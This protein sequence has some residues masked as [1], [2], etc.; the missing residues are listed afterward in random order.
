MW[1]AE[2]VLKVKGVPWDRQVL[3]ATRAVFLPTRGVLSDLP[4]EAGPPGLTK[5]RQVYI[6]KK[7]LDDIYGYTS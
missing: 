4:S 7:D 6:L 1:D 3:R 5:R 2:L